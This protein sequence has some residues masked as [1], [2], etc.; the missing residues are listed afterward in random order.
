MPRSPFEILALSTLTYH[1]DLR[2]PKP[3]LARS[4]V[5][6]EGKKHACPHARPG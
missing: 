1:T 2:E 5:L 6:A 4:W 3:I